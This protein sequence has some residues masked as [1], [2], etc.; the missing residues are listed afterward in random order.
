MAYAGPIAFPVVEGGTGDTSFT[1]YSVITG[2]TTTT[3]ALQNVSGVGTSG[4]VLTSNGASALPTW[5]NQSGN[6]PLS[7]VFVDDD[8]LTYETFTNTSSNP[9]IISSLLWSPGGTAQATTNVTG[10]PGIIG[11]A[12]SS[13][14]LPAKLASQL[15]SFA[16]GPVFLTSGAIVLTWIIQLQTLSN[17]TNRYSIILG[18]NAGGTSNQLYFT[19]SDNV[20]SGKWQLNTNN[21]VTGAVVDS[22]VA[23]DTNWHKFQITTNAGATSASFFIDGVQTA[24]SPIVTGI[25][26]APMDFWFTQNRTFGTIPSNS[27]LVD[28]FSFQQTLNT[29]R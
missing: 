28:Y 15:P 21:G 13:S 27:V 11:W 16:D 22:G 25:P 6:N 9:V 26:T 14:I 19:Y 3:G 18:A 8:F 24:N 1:A 2:G 10:H 5:Q 17:S 23:A 4:Q 29:P 12:S 7:T 20:N